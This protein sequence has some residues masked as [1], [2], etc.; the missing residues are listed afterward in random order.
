MTLHL[1]TPAYYVNDK[2]HLAVRTPTLAC[3]ARPVPAFERASGVV[4][5]R[6][7]E[8]GLKIQRTQ[9]PAVSAPGPR[10]Q[11]SETYEKLLQRWTISNESAFHPHHRPRHRQIVEQFY[12]RVELQGGR[13]WWKGRQQGC[14]CVALAKSSRMSPRA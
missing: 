14:T 5:Y 2:P 9:K 3:D 7:D 1:T 6:C 8:H 13:M 4:H 12:R 10:D 11:V